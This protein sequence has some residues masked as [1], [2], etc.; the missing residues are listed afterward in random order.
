MVSL[1][2]KYFFQYSKDQVSGFDPR[3]ISFCNTVQINLPLPQTQLIKQLSVCCTEFIRFTLVT[4]HLTRENNRCLWANPTSK[5]RTGRIGTA[6]LH[7]LLTHCPSAGRYKWTRPTSN[8]LIWLPR[9]PKEGRTW[10]NCANTTLHTKSSLL[11]KN[12]E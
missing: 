2:S 11:W 5:N 1:F 12:I 9:A 3:W 4:H 8:I 7:H 10:G 6:W